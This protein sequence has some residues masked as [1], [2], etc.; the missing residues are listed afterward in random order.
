M[1]IIAECNG[2]SVGL[3]RITIDPFGH[4]WTI[5]SMFDINGNRTQ[6]L[7]LASTCVILYNGEYIPQDVDDVPIYTVH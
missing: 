2:K 1:T 7:A 4:I 6:D 5:V 3:R